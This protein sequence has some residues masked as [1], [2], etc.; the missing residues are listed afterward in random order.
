MIKVEIEGFAELTNKLK[1][2][3]RQAVNVTV[4]V[5]YETPYALYVHENLEM[6]LEGEPRSSGIGV[7]W[8]RPNAPGRSKFLEA[9][10]I[11]HGK[12]FPGFIKYKLKQ[13]RSL[14]QAM[15]SLGH[16]ILKESKKLVPVE[17]EDLIDSGFVEAE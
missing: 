15:K 7:Y 3:Q 14:R 6:V 17:H 4:S 12:E 2:L 1:K 9:V 5:G 8:G 11:E 16:V 10:V 13:G